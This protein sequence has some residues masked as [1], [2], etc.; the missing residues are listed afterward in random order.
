M[1]RY[2]ATRLAY[3][4]PVIWLVVSVV[5]LLIHLVPGDPVQQ[6]MGEGVAAADLQAVRH[7][8]GLDV[9]LPTQYVRYWNGVL[10]GDLGKSIRFNQPVT[11]MVKA[12]YPATIS[13]TLASL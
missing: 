12:A 7:N 3:T 9:S 5:F 2:I 10:H 6:M 13:L 1:F 11:K 8:L 4:L